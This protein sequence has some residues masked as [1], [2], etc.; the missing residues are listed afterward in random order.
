MSSRRS[1]ALEL[2]VIERMFWFV[3]TGQMADQGAPLD[4][5]GLAQLLGKPVELS[6]CQAEA[7]HTRIY[8]QNGRPFPVPRSGGSPIGDLPGIVEDRHEAKFEKIIRATGRQTVK[9]GDLGRF[10][11]C[12]AKC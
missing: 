5:I 12:R 4:R 1:K 7:A 8:M 6:D 11:Q 2:E 9:D 10:G 3:R